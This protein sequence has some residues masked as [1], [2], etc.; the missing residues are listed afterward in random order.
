[1]AVRGSYLAGIVRLINI[2]NQALGIISVGYSI[3]VKSLINHKIGF[4]YISV[5]IPIV[6]HQECV[7][8]YVPLMLGLKWHRIKATITL[9][10]HA[11][12]VK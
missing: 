9:R 5:A 2:N 12:S 6:W 8:L 11:G 3:I 10:L 7:V 4:L 1:M